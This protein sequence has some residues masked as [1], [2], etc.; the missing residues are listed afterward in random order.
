MGAECRWNIEELCGWQDSM[1][2]G[3]R[4]ERSALQDFDDTTVDKGHIL[5]CNPNS[6]AR[7]PALTPILVEYSPLC[8]SINASIEPLLG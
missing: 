1:S 7:E 2:I 8:L 3:N 6:L 4:E 5:S